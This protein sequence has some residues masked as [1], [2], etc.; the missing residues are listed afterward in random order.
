MAPECWHCLGSTGT[1]M[2][3]GL[4]RGA[5][6]KEQVQRVKPIPWAPAPAESQPGSLDWSL[7]RMWSN[8][9]QSDLKGSLAREQVSESK[10]NLPVTLAG[11]SYIGSHDRLRC[12]ISSY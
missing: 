1:G 10:A 4:G 2:L 5:S 8:V 12:L 7:P 6:P 3:E 11:L 9:T